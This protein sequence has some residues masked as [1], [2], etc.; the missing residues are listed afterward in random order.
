MIIGVIEVR[1][2]LPGIRSLKG[3]RQILKSLKDRLRNKFN[4]SVGE[5]DGHD[6]W[7]S[8]TIGVA[9]VSGDRAYANTVLSKVADFFNRQPEIVIVDIRMEWY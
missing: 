6:L 1:M 5:L 4:V 3:K 7:Q 8:S 9:I 2:H